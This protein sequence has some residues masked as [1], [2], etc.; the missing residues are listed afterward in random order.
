MEIV[1]STISVEKLADQL[2]VQPQS[3]RARLCRKG[4]Y[5]GLKPVK[6]LNGRLGFPADSISRLIRPP[7]GESQAQNAGRQQAA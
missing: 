4:D 3:I 6:F 1:T 5:F 7:N 2:G